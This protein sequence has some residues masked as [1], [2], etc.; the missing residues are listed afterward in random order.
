MDAQQLEAKLLEAVEKAETAWLDEKDEDLA[1]KREKIYMRAKDELERFQNQQVAGGEDYD[2]G[3]RCRP[4]WRAAAGVR[5][6]GGTVQGP[7]TRAG[8]G[9][10]GWACRAHQDL[11]CPP[12]QGCTIGLQSKQSFQSA[13][14]AGIKKR[15]W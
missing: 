8:G 13:F 14:F 7:A 3:C 10:R 6:A 12:Y 1:P 5:L 9:P 4:A 2:Q 11:L 15:E